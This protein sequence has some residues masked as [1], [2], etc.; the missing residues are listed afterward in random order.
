MVD[1]VFSCDRVKYGVE[2][3]NNGSVLVEEIK[4]GV[5]EF[6]VVE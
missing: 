3:W 1:E 2:V 4:V 6:V 5:Y